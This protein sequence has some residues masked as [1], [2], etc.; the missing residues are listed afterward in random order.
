LPYTRCTS[1][2]VAVVP[3][4]CNFVNCCGG[5]SGAGCSSCTCRAC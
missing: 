3:D 5:G 4:A 1:A 2:D